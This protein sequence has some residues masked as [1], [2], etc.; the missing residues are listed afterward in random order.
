MAICHGIGLSPGQ[1]LFVSKGRKRVSIPPVMRQ[2]GSNLRQN[3]F[4]LRSS[5]GF[6]CT[7]G[8][9]R[10]NAHWFEVRRPHI[11][12]AFRFKAGARHRS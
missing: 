10:L 1:R 5:S 6:Y 11:T 2:V 3:S 4:P 9:E 12:A 7:L 8:D